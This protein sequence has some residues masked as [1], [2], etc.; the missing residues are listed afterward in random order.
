MQREGRAPVHPELFREAAMVAW[1]SDLDEELLELSEQPVLDVD[2][3]I[4]RLEDRGAPLQEKRELV[5]ALGALGGPRAAMALRHY[6]GDPDPG[7]E[8][9]AQLALGQALA[10]SP[11]GG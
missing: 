3:L 4:A 8:S 10:R 11:D 6:L 2:A 1:R 5:F 9:V 7:L